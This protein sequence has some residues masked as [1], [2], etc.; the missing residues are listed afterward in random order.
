MN[1]KVIFCISL[2][3]NYSLLQCMEQTIQLHE[4]QL[5]DTILQKIVNS[6]R[7]SPLEIVN[8]IKKQYQPH[9]APLSRENIAH[10]FDLNQEKIDRIFLDNVEDNTIRPLILSLGANIN[11][12]TKRTGET[13]LWKTTN[14][15]ILSELIKNGADVNAVDNHNNTPLSSLRLY[16][17]YRD[18]LEEEEDFQ[19]SITAAHVL[20]SHG[21]NP[22]H[23]NCHHLPYLMDHCKN[24][25]HILYAAQLFCKYKLD[26]HRIDTWKRPLL[27]QAI[28]LKN[29]NLVKLFLEYGAEAN[30]PFN[31]YNQEKYPLHAALSEGSWRNDLSPEQETIILLL[32]EYGADPNKSYPNNHT[33]SNGTTKPLHIAAMGNNPIIVKALLTYGAQKDA[34]NDDPYAHIDCIYTALD[35]ALNNL[36]LYQKAN[37]YDKIQQTSEIIALLSDQ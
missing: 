24:K 23:E 1:I 9:P 13:C 3:S 20:L 8:L 35:I 37:N 21:A 2:L 11:A 28:D 10:V 36:K 32:L 30:T 33:H 12:R 22:N 26:L 7:Y 4:H 6:A 17:L 27:I 15:N 34:R 25:D 29:S 18:E 5:T 16:D 31:Y 19:K 14:E